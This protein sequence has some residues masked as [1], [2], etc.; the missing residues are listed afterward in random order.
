[1]HAC[2]VVCT[3][4]LLSM[5]LGIENLEVSFLANDPESVTI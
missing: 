2:I 5:G 4:E 1:M 3:S